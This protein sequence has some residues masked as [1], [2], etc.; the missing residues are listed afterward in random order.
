LRKP[1]PGSGAENL[2]AH[3]RT[4]IGA[5]AE[6]LFGRKNRATAELPAS[7]S[8]GYGRVLERLEFCVGVRA[9]FAVQVDL[10]VL[11]GNPFHERGSLREFNDRQEDTTRSGKVEEGKSSI[12]NESRSAFPETNGDAPVELAETDRGAK[13]VFAHPKAPY[14]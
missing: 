11:R 13:L 1:A 12:G 7:E 4:T 14:Q 3:T 2:N 6:I 9:D 8:G 5:L 10:F